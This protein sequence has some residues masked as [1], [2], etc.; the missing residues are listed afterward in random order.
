[1]NAKKVRIST[2]LIVWGMIICSTVSAQKQATN[3]YGV[4]IG[5]GMS[6]LHYTPIIAKSP[7][8]SYGGTFG[9]SYK[10]FFNEHIAIATGIEFALYTGKIEGKQF[11]SEQ[12]INTPIGLS[13]NF[14][15][16]ST[17]QN[18]K[19]RQ[20]S[21]MIT[22]PLKFHYQTKGLHKFYFAV[23]PTLGIPLVSTYNVN[24][25]YIDITGYSDYNN[26]VFEDMPAH[27]FRQY[28]DVKYNDKLKLSICG[29]ASVE[30]GMKWR[31]GETTSLY[32]GL[33]M[34][35]GFNNIRQQ[36]NKELLVYNETTPDAYT[37]NSMLHSQTMQG[38]K[39]IDNVV[40]IAIG[41]KIHVA[42]GSKKTFSTGREA[43]IPAALPPTPLTEPTAATP[44]AERDKQF[45]ELQTKMEIL[46]LQNKLFQDK[47]K[48]LEQQIK[49]AQERIDN[50]ELQGKEQSVV[51][52]QELQ[53]Q[54]QELQQNRQQAQELQRQIEQNRVQQQQ[55]Q[56]Q[57]PPQ[58]RQVIPENAAQ[59]ET[60]PQKEKM[61]EV[62]GLPIRKYSVV[63]GSFQHYSNA[64][65]LKELME[66]QGYK[67]TVYQNETGMYRVVFATFN[68]KASAINERER[69]R[70]KYAPDF[71]DTWII[72][73]E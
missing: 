26:Q 6:A 52:Q 70:T 27:G 73:R 65:A 46:E 13:G 30:V 9:G 58:Q 2:L 60:Q 50:L 59:S 4:L 40:P 16:R 1:M 41:W 71:Q 12:K 10:H 11:F 14:Y 22:I 68:D 54:Q 67:I 39:Y 57:Q 23:G 63:I 64:I 61:K 31:V 29:M 44:N 8:M 45:K 37:Y 24:I 36:S 47:I 35:Y 15:L 51:Q 69:I 28:G 34:D 25:G 18:Y 72:E 21:F 5:G 38:E 7:F 19:E 43:P 20:N 32:T 33:Y 3:E 17:Y 48:S 49:E 42:I 53:Q 56:Q 62:E 66:K 55:Q